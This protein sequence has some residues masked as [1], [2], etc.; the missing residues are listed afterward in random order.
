[1][2]IN[3]HCRTCDK[4]DSTKISM[5]EL[6]KLRDKEQNIIELCAMYIKN[7]LHNSC[8][9]DIGVRVSNFDSDWRKRDFDSEINKSK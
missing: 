7:N 2:I 6:L 8:K 4:Q 3:Y 1:M 9:G 5:K